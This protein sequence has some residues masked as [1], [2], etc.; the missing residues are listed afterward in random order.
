VILDNEGDV[1]FTLPLWYVLAGRLYTVLYLVPPE[2]KL[3]RHPRSDTDEDISSS[4]W[5]SE[6]AATMTGR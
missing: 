3:K 2:R 6:N 4:P 5:I 1:I